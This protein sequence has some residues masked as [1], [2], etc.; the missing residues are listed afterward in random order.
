M[1]PVCFGN[2]TSVVV[3]KSDNAKTFSIRIKTVRRIKNPEDNKRYQHK[4]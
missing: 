1:T 2:F 3:V 4:G